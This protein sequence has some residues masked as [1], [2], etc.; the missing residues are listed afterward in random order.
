MNKITQMC[1]HTAPSI[2]LKQTKSPA[3]EATSLQGPLSLR[4]EERGSGHEAGCEATIA[5]MKNAAA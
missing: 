1:Q 4:E 2:K 3:C 5:L